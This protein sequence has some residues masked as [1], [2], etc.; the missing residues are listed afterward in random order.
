MKRYFTLLPMAVLAFGAATAH[1]QSA[2]ADLLKTLMTEQGIE[3]QFAVQLETM[4]ESVAGQGTELLKQMTGGAQPDARAA[5]TMDRFIER[6]ARMFTAEE[7][8]A[9][10]TMQYGSS[11]LSDEDLGQLIAHY[12]S[13]LGRKE[14]AANQRALGGFSAWLNAE[15]F[16]RTTALLTDLVKELQGAQR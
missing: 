9:Q 2:R 16:K 12:R 10:W 4:R 6:T 11:N 13:P 14:V 1:A 7:F 15:S 8:A 3:A 5:A